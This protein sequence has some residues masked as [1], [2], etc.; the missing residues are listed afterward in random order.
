[1]PQSRKPAA[2]PCVEQNNSALRLEL[3][4]MRTQ[5]REQTV[6]LVEASR[7]LS[8]L[9]IEYESERIE[10]CV[11]LVGVN[12]G[13][14]EGSL[15]GGI[16]KND[17]EDCV[18]SRGENG[19]KETFGLAEDGLNQEIHSPPG[20]DLHR[21]VERLIRLL[22]ETADARELNHQASQA[23]AL[24]AERER[25]AWRSESWYFSVGGTRGSVEA[26]DCIRPIPD[27]ERAADQVCQGVGRATKKAYR[28]VGPPATQGVLIPDSRLPR[29]A[30][31]TFAWSLWKGSLDRRGDFGL[32]PPLVW[33]SADSI[34]PPPP[35]RFGGEPSAQQSRPGGGGALKSRRS[36][37]APEGVAKVHPERSP[38]RIPAKALKEARKSAKP[39]RERVSGSSKPALWDRPRRVAHRVHG[40]SSRTFQVVGEARALR[41][42]RRG[43]QS[44][45]LRTLDTR[46]G[47]TV[48]KNSS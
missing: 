22:Q 30:L 25:E 11:K 45:A 9:D 42:R 31:Q 28:K 40:G 21:K 19:A 23:A 24:A 44:T 29:S 46:G 10:E 35:Q 12:E 15:E 33:P 39:T 6:Q 26:F 43:R 18:S 4:M 8:E 36:E 7:R 20:V 47:L 14:T 17:E 37:A 38:D 48:R 3:A 34:P 41:P 2:S 1:M 27:T 16:Y 32:A 13:T 5:L